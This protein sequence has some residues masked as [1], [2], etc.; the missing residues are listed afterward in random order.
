MCPGS[1][2]TRSSSA[3][4]RSSRSWRFS[5]PRAASPRRNSGSFT[6]STRSTRGSF[7]KNFYLVVFMDRDLQPGDFRQ[8]LNLSVLVLDRALRSEDLYDA[9]P[10]HVR[11]GR[12]GRAFAARHLRERLELRRPVPPPLRRVPRPV[13]ARPGRHGLEELYLFP[14]IRTEADMHK[15]REL[16]L[17]HIVHPG[18]AR[19]ARPRFAEAARG[20][21]LAGLGRR[22]RFMV[23]RH[24]DRGFEPRCL[25]ANPTYSGREKRPY[26]LTS[27]K[28]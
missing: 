19:A 27:G 28:S 11:R 1:T 16:A 13:G 12:G 23:L 24:Q 26:G 17:T 4:P 5:A 18:Q 9:R 3:S 6:K 2:A 7:A 21:H 8:P 20:L 22:T 25:I 10:H 15:L 14:P